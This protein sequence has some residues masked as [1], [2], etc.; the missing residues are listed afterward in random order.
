M[1]FEFS[2]HFSGYPNLDSR[3]SQL[4]FELQKISASQWH[5]VKHRIVSCVIQLSNISRYLDTTCWEIV[6]SHL[7]KIIFNFRNLAVGKEKVKL[8]CFLILPFFSLEVSLNKRCAE[9]SFQHKRKWKMKVDLWST[10]SDELHYI[11][12][13]Q[14][15]PSIELP[16]LHQSRKYRNRIC[17][18]SEKFS[19]NPV[20]DS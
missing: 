3:T 19:F 2:V 6:R 12:V 11:E 13:F 15:Y 14:M 18:T 1:S 9:L 5:S 17:F 10:Y 4:K 7:A 20:S 8:I 16:P